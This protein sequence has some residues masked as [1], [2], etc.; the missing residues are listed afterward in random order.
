MRIRCLTAVGAVAA[1]GLSI[2]TAGCSARAIPPSPAHLV[3]AVPGA[4][5][6]PNGP[7]PGLRYRDGGTVPLQGTPPPASSA[8]P[9]AND[10]LSTAATDTAGATVL[11]AAD[12]GIWR[13]TDGGASWRLEKDA[14]PASSWPFGYGYRFALSGLGPSARC[15]RA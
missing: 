12:S 6:H 8:L 14:V 5:V 10:L 2:V 13:S 4:T 9:G 3:R 7:F 15:R 1:V 11:A